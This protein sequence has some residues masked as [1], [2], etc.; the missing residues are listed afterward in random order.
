MCKKRRRRHRS[1]AKVA[2]LTAAAA[3]LANQVLAQGMDWGQLDAPTPPPAR[4]FGSPSRGCLAGAEALPLDGPGW[5]VMRPSRHRYFGHPQLIA[6]IERLAADAE[7]YG[8]RHI[9]RRYGAAAGRADADRPSQPS[10]RPGCGHLVRACAT[11]SICSRRS[12]RGV[13]HLDGLRRWRERRFNELDSLASRFVAKGR[14]R[15]AG[16]PDLR[17]PRHQ[18]HSVQVGDHRPHMAA[19][20]STLVGPRRPLP[21]PSLVPRGRRCLCSHRADSGG[22]WLRCIAGVVV[23]GRSEGGFARK[24]EDTAEAIDARRPAG[25]LPSHSRRRVCLG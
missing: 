8:R 22:G 17:E 16:G 19:E 9:D 14:S 21:C 24:D 18:A 12:G 6:F 25:R 5:Q 3:L 10:D 7:Q 20:N 2:S 23:F 4:A 13:G 1:A 11:D 15:P